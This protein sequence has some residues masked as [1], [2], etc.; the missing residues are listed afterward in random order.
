MIGFTLMLVFALSIYQ[1]LPKKTWSMTLALAGYLVGTPLAVI[2]FSSVFSLVRFIF[3]NQDNVL[4][5]NEII[6]VKLNQFMM[7]NYIFGPLF[8]IIIGNCFLSYTAYKLEFFPK[9]LCLW[10]MVSAGLLFIGFFAVI[11]PPLA[12]GSIGGPLT[13]L[14]FIM[15]GVTLLRRAFSETVDS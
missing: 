9:W 5:L 12:I 14:W 4:Q 1:L 11:Y 13:M 3:V 7:T 2:S 10:A 8:V 15:C 6:G